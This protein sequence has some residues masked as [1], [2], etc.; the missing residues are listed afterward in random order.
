MAESKELTLCMGRVR[1]LLPVIP[2]LWE[3]EVGKSLEVRWLTS[4]IPALWEADTGGTPEIRSSRPVWSTCKLRS[5]E[6]LASSNPSPI[7]FLG[8]RVQKRQRR[9]ETHQTKGK[10]GEGQVRKH[11]IDKF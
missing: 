4:V 11:L 10:G 2:A 9:Q 1:W 7:Q 6:N 8:K 3:A 5:T